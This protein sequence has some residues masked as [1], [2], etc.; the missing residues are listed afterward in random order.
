MNRKLTY[1]HAIT[2]ATDQA[3]Q[4][5]DSVILIGQGTRDRGYIFGS[6]EG[7]YEK[8]G[9]QR[10]IEMPL[11]ENA[12]A[13]ICVGAALNGLRPVFILQRVDFVFLALDQLL[14]HASK[15]HFMFGG[16]V[17]VPITIRLIIGKGWGQGPQ[18]SQSLHSLFSHFPGVRVAIPSNPYDAKGILLNGIFSDDP[19]V[20]FE[21]RPLYSLEQDVP[22]NPYLI[23]FGQANILKDGTDITIISTSFL[24][25]EALKASSELLK[26]GISAEVID[27]VSASPID[28]ETITKSVAKTGRL[29]ITDISWDRCGISAEISALVNERLFNKL[30]A[31]ISRLTV[32]FSPAPTGVEM[33]K[34][35]YPTSEQIIEKCKQFTSI[36]S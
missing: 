33:E 22:V 16:K 26:V 25:S 20:I 27:L 5:D 10:V 21:G 34:K 17:K 15:Y 32:P 35:Y 2:E 23:P 3:M 36:R 6:V 19:V 8:Y 31:P 30:K 7:L 9:E 12:I 29:L 24:V 1:A 28:I 14:N 4:M 18:H 13:G 11:S